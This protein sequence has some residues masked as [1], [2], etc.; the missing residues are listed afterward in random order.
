[1][2]RSKEVVHSF[3]RKNARV[4]SEMSDRTLVGVKLNEIRKIYPDLLETSFF[5]F[6]LAARFFDLLA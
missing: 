1:L 5:P 4:Q 2:R 3:D 6:T